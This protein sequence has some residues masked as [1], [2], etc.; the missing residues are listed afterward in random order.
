MKIEKKIP[1]PLPPKSTLDPLSLVL[2]LRGNLMQKN[3]KKKFEAPP[4]VY[5]IYK[6]QFSGEKIGIDK[7][8]FHFH[9]HTST[10]LL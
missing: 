1:D 8:D 3:K 10:F 7:A 5:K 2:I 6:A 9:K 4:L